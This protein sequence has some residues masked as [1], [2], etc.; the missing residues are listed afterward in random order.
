VTVL[1]LQCLRGFTTALS[2]CHHPRSTHLA[3]PSR[4]FPRSCTARG[5]AEII[6]GGSGNDDTDDE[7]GKNSNKNKN[8]MTEIV[9]EKLALRK[10]D[11]VCS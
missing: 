10:L 2:V 4:S 3:L 11:M 7:D 6:D 9:E 8:I 1:V 5:M